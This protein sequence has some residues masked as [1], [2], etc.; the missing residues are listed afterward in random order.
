MEQY[1]V[2][3]STRVTSVETE[4]PQHTVTPRERHISEPSPVPMAIGSIPSTVVRVVM[5]IGR[6]RLRAA[7]V[8]ASRTFMPRSRRSMV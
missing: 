2:G 1:T 6:R 3:I 8:D 7:V 5:R 4:R